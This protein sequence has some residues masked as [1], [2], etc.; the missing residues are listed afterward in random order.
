TDPRNKQ[1]LFFWDQD[2]KFSGDLDLFRSLMPWIELREVTADLVELKPNSSTNLN[3]HNRNRRGTNDVFA[4]WLKNAGL[5]GHCMDS[6]PQYSGTFGLAPNDLPAEGPDGRYLQLDDQMLSACS[7]LIL[8]PTAAYRQIVVAHEIGHNLSLRHPVKLLGFQSV[9]YSSNFSQL[10]TLQPGKYTYDPS[11][12]RE[13]FTW[14]GDYY[15]PI[16]NMTDLRQADQVAPKVGVLGSIEQV[17]LGTGYFSDLGPPRRSIYNHVLVDPPNATISG[18]TV[19]AVLP[20]VFND[21][22]GSLKVNLMNW[23]PY[24]DAQ[25]QTTGSYSLRICPVTGD[26]ADD[27]HKICT[28]PTCLF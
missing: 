18:Q 1:D 6:S 26:C 13:F 27:P 3:V 2:A 9:S 24:L 23:S 15:Y 20:S 12:N 17:G 25:Y 16:P 14:L 10:A 8:F 11:P 28:K 21:Q 22:G 7:Q 19:M 5:G 4:L